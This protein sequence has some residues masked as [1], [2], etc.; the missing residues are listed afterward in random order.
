MKDKVLAGLIA[1]FVLALLLNVIELGTITGIPAHPLLLHMPV[2]FI[3]T[4]AIAAITFAFRPDWRRTYGVAYGIGA[5]VTTAGTVLAANAGEKWE[6]TLSAVDQMAI[7]D[8]AELG[9]TLKVVVMVFAALIL[10]QVAVDRGALGK[11]G[12]RLSAPTLN[13]WL[14]ILVAA[15]AI[16]AGALTVATGH[17]GAKAVFGHDQQ[18]VEGP[19][20]GGPDGDG[21]YR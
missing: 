14:G 12:E 21:D 18:T 5:I 6:G 19:P 10:L 17:A 16:G 9:D 15:V 7:H 2:I 11:I 13:L 20:G 1:G 4:L 3:P 8:H